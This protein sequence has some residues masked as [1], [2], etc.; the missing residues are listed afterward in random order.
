MPIETGVFMAFLPF[1]S[2]LRGKLHT[3]MILP[4][5]HCISIIPPPLFHDPSLQLIKFK[6]V[7]QLQG[8]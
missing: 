7:F 6:D 3:S 2:S 1:L 4:H 5:V 8:I